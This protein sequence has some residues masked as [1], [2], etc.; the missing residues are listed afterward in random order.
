MVKNRLTKIA[1]AARG[2]NFFEIFNSRRMKQ[3]YVKN[4]DVPR[5]DEKKFANLDRKNAL[6]MKNVENRM[7]KN[8][9]ASQESNYFVT[10]KNEM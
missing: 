1:L 4:C 7:T 3:H 2:A 5:S 10:Q 8:S 9:S 6:F